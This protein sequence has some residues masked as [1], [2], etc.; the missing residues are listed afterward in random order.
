[1]I[2]S[3]VEKSAGDPRSIHAVAWLGAGA[4]TLGIGAALVSGSSLAHAETGHSSR[5]SGTSGTHAGPAKPDR[6]ST[7]SAKAKTFTPIR[8]RAAVTANIAAGQ[9]DTPT[10][11]TAINTVLGWLSHELQYTLFNKPPTI[12][13]IQHSE[14][15]L[16]G[17]VV[18]DFHGS[19]AT[20]SRLTYTAT[21]PDNAAVHVNPDGTFTVTPDANTAH[22]GGT[23]TFTVTADNGS[24]YRLPGLAGRI[25]AVIHSLAQ[26][27]GLSGSDTSTTVVTVD[28]AA[29]NKPPVVTGYTDGTLG[30]GGIV[31]GQMQ[32]TDL[33]G[34]TLN[35]NGST[36]TALGGTVVINSDGTFT[37]TPTASI[38]HA[39]AAINDPGAATID[40]FSINVSDGYGGVATETVHVPVSPAN[41]NP[42]GGAIT[43]L[44]VDDIIGVVTGS[45]TGV[46]DPDLDTLGYSS[47]PTSVGGGSVDVYN[48]GS[49][50]YNPTADQRHL[51]AAL[52]APFTSTHDSF[53]IFVS[54]GHGGSTAIIIVV[55]VPPEADEPP[56]GVAAG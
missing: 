53:T 44:Q 1:M 13:P 51:A 45:V 43:G 47:N 11:R 24:G 46:T 37:Y 16:T 55:P 19:G 6:H 32:A 56:T 7:G 3:A 52:G 35:F 48:D 30:S 9:I 14:D 15:P 36:T 49:F 5:E 41:G 50:T 34:D 4:I 33:N 25:Q 54:D 39:A 23:V 10:R 31:T 2:S 21:Q 20:D 29:T 8:P 38:R 22:V 12:A 17:V 18:G 26:R 42:T 27:L 28:V 40:S